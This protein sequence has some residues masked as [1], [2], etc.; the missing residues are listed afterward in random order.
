MSF[1]VSLAMTVVSS[2]SITACASLCVYLMWSAKLNKVRYQIIFLIS[3]CDMF[4]AVGTVFGFTTS[5]SPQCWVQAIFTQIFPLAS[6]FWT[7]LI[8]VYVVCIIRSIS[9]QA[10]AFVGW[11]IF[12]L[13]FGVPVV[14]TML[15]FTTSTYGCLD[16]SEPCWCFIKDK[17]DSPDWATTVWYVASFYMWIWACLLLNVGL[18]V[19]SMISMRN[20]SNNAY[21]EKVLHLLFKL[22]GYPIVVIVCW[23]CLTMMDVIRAINPHYHILTNEMYLNMSF[24]LPCFQ[25]LL[26]T[27]V[28]VI[29]HN[30]RIGK[31]D[32]M[33]SREVRPNSMRSADISSGKV[34]PFDQSQ[35]KSYGEV[36]AEVAK[37]E[38]EEESSA[39]GMVLKTDYSVGSTSEKIVVVG[40]NV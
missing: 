38:G 31:Y 11:K 21:K 7:L 40:D 6:A 10:D 28:F 8:G 23:I 24:T 16:D 19:Y 29:T 37:D 36:H 35:E 12:L 18:L 20:F 4:A 5:G 15:P 30:I 9:F 17:K 1:S 25:G 33:S 3:L 14:V 26:A 2:L 22:L 39:S 27:I 34:L 32:Y 13:C